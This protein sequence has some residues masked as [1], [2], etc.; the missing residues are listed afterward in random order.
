MEAPPSNDNHE[1]PC[2]PIFC[3]RGK[4]GQRIRKYPL[5]AL[6]QMR[7]SHVHSHV[8]RPCLQSRNRNHPCIWKQRETRYCASQ[9]NHPHHTWRRGRG[10][11]GWRSRAHLLGAHG[12][13][14]ILTPSS[15][16]YRIMGGV[17][18]VLQT[19]SLLSVEL[20]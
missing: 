1:A 8:R 19:S 20:R 4:E 16:D 5:N 6:A 7:L 17:T 18:R 9:P 10:R 14:E 3:D 11:G 12:R 13:G 2:S 15:T